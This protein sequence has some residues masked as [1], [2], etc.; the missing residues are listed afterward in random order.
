MILENANSKNAI[1]IKQKIG[2]WLSHKIVWSQFSTQR[3]LRTTG[4][5]N[6]LDRMDLSCYWFETFIEGKPYYEERAWNV[7]EDYYDCS[8]KS[9]KEDVAIYIDKRLPQAYLKEKDHLDTSPSGVKIKL[10]EDG[11]LPYGLAYKYPE[12]YLSYAPSFVAPATEK[13]IKYLEHLAMKNGY[14]FN[15]NGLTKEKASSFITFLLNMDS[16]SE[17]ENF[18]VHFNKAI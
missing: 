16:V 11:N 14:Y 1:W 5:L 9:F 7:I 6:E 8:Y 15:K 4:E 17:P 2:E 18:N 10:D 12:N 13:Q 3:K